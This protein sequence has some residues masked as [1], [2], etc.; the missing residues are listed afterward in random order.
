MSAW[1]IMYMTCV[2]SQLFVFI[3]IQMIVKNLVLYQFWSIWLPYWRLLNYDKPQHECIKVSIVCQ[4]T[5]LVHIVP[6]CTFQEHSQFC[7]DLLLPYVQFMMFN[8]NHVIVWTNDT[9]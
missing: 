7:Q 3:M 1:Y 9:W 6:F 8:R 2:L 5:Y 4:Y